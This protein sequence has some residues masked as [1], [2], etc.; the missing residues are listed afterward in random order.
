MICATCK[1]ELP[2]SSFSIARD[3]KRGYNYHCK[4]CSAVLRKKRKLRYTEE[5]LCLDC[6]NPLDR[7]GT[8]C[9]ACA[10]GRCIDK[11]LLKIKVMNRYGGCRCSC[12]GCNENNLTQLSI[13]HINGD[14]AKHRKEIGRGNYI[15]NWLVKHDYPPGFR[16]LCLGCNSSCGFFG[17]CIHES[18]QLMYRTI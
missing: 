3:R 15:Y 5:K 7:G 18:R 1:Q 17:F 10:S 13:D 14:G 2:V 16:V 8:R 6:S 12:P 11:Q 9:C 4:Q